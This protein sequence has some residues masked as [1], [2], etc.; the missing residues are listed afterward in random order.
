MFTLLK[1]TITTQLNRRASSQRLNDDPIARGQARERGKG[2]IR[3]RMSTLDLVSSVR[4]TVPSVPPPPYSVNPPLKRPSKRNNFIATRPQEYGIQ[5]TGACSSN[6]Y[7]QDYSRTSK[8]QQA[9]GVVLLIEESPISFSPGKAESAS[10]P[11]GALL[12]CHPESKSAST[13]QSGDALSIENLKLLGGQIDESKHSSS[14][15]QHW[16][17][18]FRRPEEGTAR[19]F[20]GDNVSRPTQRSNSNLIVPVASA[21]ATKGVLHGELYRSSRHRSDPLPGQSSRNASR[22]V[23][24]FQLYREKDSRELEIR[25]QKMDGTIWK[26]PEQGKKLEI[27]L[28]L[29]NDELRRNSTAKGK[30]NV[31]ADLS[32]SR[33]ASDNSYSAAG[34][35]SHFQSGGP[36][37]E[38]S[39]PKN[40]SP[41]SPTRTG[42]KGSQSFDNDLVVALRLQ[43]KW[44]K[45]DEEIREQR[46]FAMSLQ[47][48]NNVTLANLERLNAAQE[49]RPP[50]EMVID[51]RV[52]RDQ[53]PKQASKTYKLEGMAT[54]MADMNTRLRKAI[55]NVDKSTK[56]IQQRTEVLK[57][58]ASHR[59][60]MECV[61]CMERKEKHLIAVLECKHVYCGDCIAGKSLIP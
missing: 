44:D 41:T 22:E 28:Q 36:F 6:V 39:Q 50:R 10:L 16:T 15:Q 45:E 17:Q 4:A 42:T 40:V 56:D 3:E 24:T 34:C 20:Y 60:R 49:R 51:T 30:S 2:K 9:S 23:S 1:E 35:G 61:S 11:C 58:K 38:R 52:R 55:E 47:G 57:R 31:S 21:A 18:G 48:D 5:A 32:R 25:A 37:H 29:E 19:H 8:Y 43:S 59:L 53:V 33:I 14:S 46:E 54:S 26:V 12:S 27:E 13:Y 7:P